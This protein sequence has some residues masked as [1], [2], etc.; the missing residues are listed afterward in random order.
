[1]S[2]LNL[3]SFGGG[4]QSTA[5]LVLAAQGRI[6][7]PTFVFAHVG[8][9][10]EHP[11]TLDYIERYSKPYALAHGIEF[12]ELHRRKR[13]GSVETVYG[14]AMRTDNRTIPIPARMSNGAPGN[15]TCTVDFKLKQVERF[16]KQRG[17]TVD[18]RASVGIGF[19]VNEL[20]RMRTDDPRG[21][22]HLVYPL[23]DL[24][25]TTQD[26][27]NIVRDAGLPEPPKSACWFCPFHSRANWHALKRRRP[28][29]FQ[30]AVELERHLNVK[31]GALGRDQ[32]WLTA[33]ARPLDEVIQGEQ[34]D[35]TE[36][37]DD[38]CN[39]YSCMT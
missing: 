26:C 14:R 18:N 24:R 32:M 7:F 9:D 11:D 17:A 25:L 20:S 29:L 34:V 4:R 13:D 8:V 3:F 38:T 37:V 36:A 30:K 19:S 6:H 35:W 16:A 23:V 5:A 31:R 12:V 39:I 2:L 1:M 15:R 10:S 27:I 22:Q 33:F 28:D 21:V